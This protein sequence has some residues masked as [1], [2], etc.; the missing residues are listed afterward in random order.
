M[1]QQLLSENRNRRS[2]S[3][4]VSM[5]KLKTA[6]GNCWKYKSNRA[7]LTRHIQTLHFAN[8][9]GNEMWLCG[10]CRHRPDEPFVTARVIS[11][12]I[13]ECAQ[14]EE[15]REDSVQMSQIGAK[16]LISMSHQPIFRA[17]WRM[18]LPMATLALRKPEKCQVHIDFQRPFL[19]LQSTIKQ[20]IF[21]RVFCVLLHS[22]HLSLQGMSRILFSQPIFSLRIFFDVR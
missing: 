12:R 19:A 22:L 21:S 8:S 20:T 6:T 11:A 13:S 18:S 2:W 7:Y 15:S 14:P 9:S 17:R 16:S 3:K 5:R 1:S 4:L 10:F